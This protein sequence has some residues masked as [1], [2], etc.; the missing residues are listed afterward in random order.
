MLQPERTKLLVEYLEKHRSAPVKQIAKDLYMSETTV[1]RDLSVL[2]KQHIVRRSYG[3]AVLLKYG[4]NTLP[5]SMRMFDNRK[6]KAAIARKA[7]A[8][9]REG[10]VL[11]IDESSTSGLVAEHLDPTLDLTV[12]TS[13]LTAAGILAD[14]RIKT[15]CT[16]GLVLPDTGSFAGGYAEPLLNSVNADVCFFSASGVTETGCI[17]D[18]MEENARIKR[19]ML[20]RA[21]R[22]VFLCDHTKFGA[23]FPFV[24]A[25]A[26]DIDCLITDTDPPEPYRALFKEIV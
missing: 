11:F 14:K 26:A 10:S 20:S 13:S 21:A 16:G 3:F 9:V 2:E 12:V 15:Y 24:A 17:C 7:A 6:E 19:L 25:D 8:T 5:L 1:R 23:S 4:N 22:K 18:K